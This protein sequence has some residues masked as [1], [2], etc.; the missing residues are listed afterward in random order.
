MK[1]NVLSLVII[2]F[3]TLNVISQTFCE[4]SSYS[5]NKDLFV[6]TDNTRSGILY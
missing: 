3:L 5:P 2:V 4:T 6:N 1:K